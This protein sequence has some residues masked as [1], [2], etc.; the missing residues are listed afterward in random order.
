MVDPVRPCDIA[1]ITRIYTFKA[2]DVD[3]VFIGV[4]TALMVGVDAADGAKVVF[5]GVGA[6]LVKRQ[7]IRAFDNLQ[8]AQGNGCNDCPPPPAKAAIA[9]VRCGQPLGEGH[10]KFDRTTMAG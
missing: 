3:A 7:V 1:Q 10:R 6:P 2:R 8:I 4:G 9:A 5:C